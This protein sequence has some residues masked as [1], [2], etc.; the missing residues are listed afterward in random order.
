MCYLCAIHVLFMCY[1]CIIHVIFM[2]IF[3]LTYEQIICIVNVTVESINQMC[4]FCNYIKIENIYSYFS[5]I[6]LYPSLPPS[7][8]SL[9][10]SPSHFP[11]PSSPFPLLP[12]L[13]SLLSSPFPLLPS[14]FSLPFPFAIGTHYE[15]TP[16][17]I[18]RPLLTHVSPFVFYTIMTMR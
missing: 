8:F 11:L 3:Q 9:P 13:F 17:H 6:L 4:S 16:Q 2:C 12:S 18:P 15:L 1:L 5:F 7:P 14:L 10:P